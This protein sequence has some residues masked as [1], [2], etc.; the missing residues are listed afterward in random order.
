MYLYYTNDV[1]ISI[2]KPTRLKDFFL[3][4]TLFLPTCTCHLVNLT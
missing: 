4:A 2:Q 1:R 3:V